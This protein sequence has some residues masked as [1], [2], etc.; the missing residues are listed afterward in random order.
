MATA[1]GRRMVTMSASTSAQAPRTGI[2][3]L[4]DIENISIIAAPGRTS[5][6]VQGELIDQCTLLQYRFAVLDAIPFPNGLDT[7]KL[8]TQRDNY[9][10]SYVAHLALQR[11]H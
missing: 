11:S 2:Q 4:K 5:V 1:V 10:T 6:T 3:A 9:D 8:L 7:N